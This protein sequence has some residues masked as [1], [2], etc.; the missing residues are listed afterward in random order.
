[1][2][3]LPLGD[4]LTVPTKSMIESVTLASVGDSVY[5]EDSD[6]LAL[7]QKVAE[8]T[9][10][11]A[12]LFCVSGTLSNQIGLRTQLLQP[13][14]TVLCDY[15][16]HVYVHEAGGLAT[17]S[18][19][20]VSPVKPSNGLYLTLEDVVENFIEDGDIH[21]APTKVVSLENTIHGI[22]HPIEEIKRI[23]E[24]CKSNGI[25]LHLDGARIWNASVA[26]GLSIKDIAK[27]FDSVS[28]C[29]SKGLAAP[30]GS[31]LV[32]PKA[33][34]QKA[35]HFKK[36]NGG[37][38]R[39]SGFLARMASIA[40]DEN[41]P[42][43]QYSH[44]LAKD[45]AD[46][47]VSLG[48]KLECP[49]DTNFV[50]FDPKANSIDPNLVAKLSEKYE[51]KAYGFRFAFSFQNSKESVERLKLLTKELLELSEKAPAGAPISNMTYYS[52]VQK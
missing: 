28:L 35:N 3:T 36:Q 48:I 52:G 33:F 18:Q 23:S 12:G 38:I 9:G 1:M 2:L 16:A 24:W 20:M 39:Q 41:L 50:F 7:E 14:H 29:L 51:I 13:P 31:V 22:I 6:T 34:I 32:G 30:I 15:R 49:T 26:T 44:D 43:L 37:G 8:L 47:A 45:F 21:R 4:T 25:K 19:A 5:N 46:Y 42:K 27:Y 10:H 17:L 40:I 11:E